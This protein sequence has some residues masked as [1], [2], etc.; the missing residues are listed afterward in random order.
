MDQKIID[1][2]DEY[3]HTRLDRRVFLTRLAKL[4]GSVGVAAA[5]IPLLAANQA[6][7]AIVAA[8][9]PRLETERISY[10]G[11][12]GDVK[13]YMARPKGTARLPSVIVIHENR[14]LNPHIEDV[15]RR[16]A[17]EGFLVLAPD[18]LSPLGG[19]PE[20]EDTARELIA[21]LD[22]EQTVANLRKAVDFLAKHVRASGKVGAVGFC[23]GGGM[24]GD[25]AV[26]APSLAAAVVYYGRQPK[27]TD[28]KK[29]QAPLLL[30]YAGLDKR[31]NEGIAEFESALKQSNKTYEL[32]VYAEVNHAFNNDTSAARYNKQAAELAWSRTVA[33]L[34]RNLAA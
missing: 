17:L 16:M 11:A 8:S 34:K 19:T 12:T 29:I 21:K 30:H 10:P 1:L 26:H 18:L 5:L 25:L 22:G 20:N 14:G 32:H 7:A 13:A 4:T 9:D 3:T 2:Y 33:F 28:V 24:V 31:I 27:G 23:W 6:R 15:A